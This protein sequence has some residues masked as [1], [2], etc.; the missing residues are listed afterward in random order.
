MDGLP[1]RGPAHA[2]QSRELGSLTRWRARWR[3][4]ATRSG[5]LRESSRHRCLPCARPRLAR[6]RP[7]GTATGTGTMRLGPS[8]VPTRRPTWLATPPAGCTATK[9]AGMNCRRGFRLAHAAGSPAAAPIARV[10]A[11]VHLGHAVGGR[12]LRPIA[13]RLGRMRRPR[14]W[15]PAFDW[16][17]QAL[18]LPAHAHAQPSDRD[19]GLWSMRCVRCCAPGRT[20]L[21]L[22]A[23]TARC[24]RPT[25]CARRTNGRS[26]CR[27]D[28]ATCCR[29]S[30]QSAT[31]CCWRGQ[32]PRGWTGR[33]GASV[34]VIDVA[35]RRPTTCSR[36]GSMPSAAPGATRSATSSC[37]R[38]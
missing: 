20:R 35:V 31:A 9:C 16:S 4:C 27:A 26:S 34:V 6:A 5:L 24:A 10:A 15:C 7:A 17:G 25:C 32:L 21:L 11:R 36:R 33:R 38:R 29:S 13:T 37:R 30:F 14:C 22:F 2:L 1:V 12:G 8:T 28:A 23:C 19:H 18:V 3:R